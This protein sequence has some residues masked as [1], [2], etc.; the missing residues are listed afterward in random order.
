[1]FLCKIVKF[2]PMH[3]N[4]VDVIIYNVLVLIQYR[5]EICFASFD[6]VPHNF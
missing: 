6:F 4:L 5:K 3:F 1:M 2:T